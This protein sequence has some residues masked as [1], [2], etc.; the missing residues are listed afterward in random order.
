MSFIVEAECRQCG[1]TNDL[2]EADRLLRCR[3]CGVASLLSS[4]DYFRYVLPPRNKAEKIFYIPYVRFRGSVFYC[5]TTK[6]VE[7]RVVDITQRGI[8]FPALPASLGI[9]PQA[10]KLRFAASDPGAVYLKNRLTLVEALAGVATLSSLF[11]DGKFYHRAYIGETI[12]IIYQPVVVDGDTLVDA[13][14]EVRLGTAGQETGTL[15]PEN[16]RFAWTVGMMAGLCP[17]CGWD[18]E[19]DADSF[20]FHCRNCQTAWLP[21]LKGFKPLE[22]RVIGGG[23]ADSVYLPFWRIK[24]SAPAVGI[25][26]FADF[27]RVTNQP[28]VPK[29]LWEKRAMRYLVPAFKIRP[30]SFLDLAS[31]MTISQVRLAGSKEIL[32]DQHH[33]VTLPVSEAVQSLKVTLANSALNRNDIF[34]LLPELKFAVGGKE[35]CYLPFRTTQHDLVQVHTGVSVNRKALEYGRH[36]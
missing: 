35:L 1:T 33:S 27:V 14:T 10:M 32:P 4:D 25:D 22:Y 3:S 29:A 6:S 2:G 8:D 19:G 17:N 12:S 28:M 11:Q 13:V 23:E 26:S 15:F 21:T 36:L 30:K 34:P 16:R 31:R 7:H 20:A 5:K 9:R 18:L 24:A